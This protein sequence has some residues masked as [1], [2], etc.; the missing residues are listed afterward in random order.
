MCYAPSAFRF[1]AMNGDVVR[2]VAGGGLDD[3]LQRHDS[4]LVVAA[5]QLELLRLERAEGA[6]HVLADSLNERDLLLRVALLVVERLRVLI[7]I[8]R[9]Q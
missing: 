4:L 9:E 8:G 3:L 7:L 2:D 5:G 1:S 6:G